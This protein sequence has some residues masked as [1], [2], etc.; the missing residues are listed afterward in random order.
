MTKTKTAKKATPVTK[1]KA[2]QKP[3]A[4]KAASVKNKTVSEEPVSQKIKDMKSS[5]NYYKMPKMT[6]INAKKKLYTGAS[7]FSGCG[8]SS[9]GHKMA[10]INMLYAN[11]YVKAAQDTYELNHPA[12]F[13]D[14]RDIRTVTAK[15]VLKHMGLKKGDLDL[16]DGSP[17]C[18]SYS[19]AGTRDKGWNKPK[20]Y[21]DE[22][23]QRT[24]D[25]FQEFVRILKGVMPKTF[26]VENVPG[27]V[28]GSAKGV[29]LEV[30]EAF[31]EAGYVVSARILNASYLGVPQARE[32]LIFVGVRNDLAKMGFK[33]VHP[34]ALPGPQPTVRDALPHIVAI[35]RVTN[36]ILTYVP[37]DVPSPTITAS[38][39]T[40][41]ETAAFSCG[42]FVET[43]DGERRKYTIKELKR[44]CAFPPDFQFTGKYRQKFERM[45]RA[46]PPLMMAKVTKEIINQILT[47]YY[48]KISK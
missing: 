29:F 11:E 43:A 8:G 46:V 42:G 2:A 13:M 21:S 5:D 16:L 4:K 33:P 12:T 1:S 20:H 40:N 15:E 22:V 32:R 31:K 37:S 44:I 6:A 3:E 36:G 23:F 25:L 10:G 47:P 38:D 28:H 26:V 35:K 45:G 41:S 14:R 17:P 9:T 7:F 48:A 24:D 34:E 18:S 27:L 30:M 19:A 39:G